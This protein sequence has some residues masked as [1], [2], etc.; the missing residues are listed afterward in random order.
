MRGP[1]CNRHLTVVPGKVGDAGNIPSTRFHYLSSLPALS[2][3]TA[4]QESGLAQ[5]VQ[6]VEIVANLPNGHQVE[7]A[8]DLC[9]Q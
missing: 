3:D 7:P 2:V 4:R 5:P 9:Q 6:T 1:L 8:E